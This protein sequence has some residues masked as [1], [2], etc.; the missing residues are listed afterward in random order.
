MDAVAY[1][2]VAVAEFITKNLIPIRIQA[3]NLEVA[4]RFLIKWTPSLL[5][6]DQKGVQHQKTVGY[7]PPKELIPVLLLGMGKTYFDQPDRP[8]A[9]SYFE[10]I[11]SSYPTCFQ[12]PG[13]IYFRGVSRYIESHDAANLIAI[14]DQLKAEYPDSEW[15]MRSDPYR[16]LK[17]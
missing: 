4:P 12:A 3:D 16:L 6:L 11:I 9:I 10:Q 5:I 8:K 17:K 2:D 1:P 15:F 14:Y 13:A 7:F